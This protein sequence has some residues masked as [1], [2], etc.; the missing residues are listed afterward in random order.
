[1]YQPVIHVQSCSL[2]RHSDTS[3]H[4]LEKHLHEL[5]SAFS[6]VYASWL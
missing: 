5:T 3:L 2:I 4:T 1:M 6:Q